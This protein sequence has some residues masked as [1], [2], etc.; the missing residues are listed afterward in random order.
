[1]DPATIK[2]HTNLLRLAKG[3]L[4]FYEDWLGEQTVC[5][6]SEELKKERAARAQALDSMEPRK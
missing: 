2:L 3:A 4:K 6:M 5:A 1:M